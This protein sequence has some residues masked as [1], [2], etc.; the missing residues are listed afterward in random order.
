MIIGS[1]FSKSSKEL[2]RFCFTSQ[3]LYIGVTKYT[4]WSL[5]HLTECSP[6]NTT[7]KILGRNVEEYS[8]ADAHLINQIL[9]AK[10]VE[11]DK[12]D[13]AIEQLKSGVYF[14]SFICTNTWNTNQTK[15]NILQPII[16]YNYKQTKHIHIDNSHLHVK[17]NKR[18]GYKIL[19]KDI[20]RVVVEDC[21]K[22]GLNRIIIFYKSVKGMHISLYSSD[23]FKVRQFVTAL[24]K[25]ILTTKD[26]C[27]IGKVQSKIWLLFKKVANLLKQA[28]GK[29][30]F[31]E[32]F[33]KVKGKTIVD[34][35]NDIHKINIQR[36]AR[37]QSLHSDYFSKGTEDNA[38]VE[39]RGE[40][41]TSIGDTTVCTEHI[42]EY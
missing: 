14:F 10:N 37:N 30:T 32:M 2:E 35:F 1:L 39:Y 9:L 27:Y 19:F 38:L 42:L 28:K 26:N 21:N 15:E 3:S 6:D 13:E 11:E 24:E 16:N 20:Q 33:K 18:K 31:K 34:E 36:D 22:N 12:L 29:Y 40:K 8:E 7:L 23:F 17:D 5:I 25:L 4:A 41:K